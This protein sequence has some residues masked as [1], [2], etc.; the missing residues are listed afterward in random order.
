MPNLYLRYKRLKF[1]GGARRADIHARAA[2]ELHRAARLLERRLEHGVEYP[3]V[4]PVR[5]CL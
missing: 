3:E 4:Q 2:R 1:H 5:L